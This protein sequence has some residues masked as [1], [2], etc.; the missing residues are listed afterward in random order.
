VGRSGRQSGTRKRESERDPAE[1]DPVHA[2]AT[3]T[4]ESVALENHLNLSRV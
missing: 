1:G 2:S 4:S 3:A